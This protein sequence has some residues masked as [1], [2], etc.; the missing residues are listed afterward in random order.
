MKFEFDKGKSTANKKK[1]GIDFVDA[2]ALWDD[3]NRLE[4]PLAYEFEERYAVVAKING[5]FWTAIVTTRSD[6][7]RFI[8]VRRSR[9]VEY[10]NYEEENEQ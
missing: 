1:H 10:F 8:S 9:E 6:K 5:K 2:Q 7:I 3:V 4:I